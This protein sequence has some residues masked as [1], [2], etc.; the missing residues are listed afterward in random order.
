MNATA[1]ESKQSEI[2]SSSTLVM[3][4][5]SLHPKVPLGRFSSNFSKPKHKSKPIFLLALN[6][7]WHKTCPDHLSSRPS[8]SFLFLCMSFSL[9]MSGPALALHVVVVVVVVTIEPPADFHSRSRVEWVKEGRK[10][11]RT[12][13]LVGSANITTVRQNKSGGHYVNVC[14]VRKQRVA[15]SSQAA[16]YNPKKT[17]WFGALIRVAQLNKKPFDKVGCR[18]HNYRKGFSN[19]KAM[20]NKCEWQTMFLVFWR[21]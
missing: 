13:S 18:Q 7:N 14:P 16:L 11:A 8:V 10:I 4:T 3:W 20:T 2:Y 15:T 5:I 9:R 1:S 21:F 6:S 19:E 17:G 12:A